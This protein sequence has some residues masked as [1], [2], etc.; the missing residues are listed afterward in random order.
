MY[1]VLLADDER[2]VLDS[3]KTLIPWDALGLELAC[4]AENGLEALQGALD[5]SPEIIISDI[6]MPLLSGLD[7][8]ERLRALDLDCEIIILSGYGEFSYAQRAIRCGVRQYLIKPTKKEELL[9][10]L[11]QT[12]DTLNL[13]KDADEKM[14]VA[15]LDQFRFPIAKG[16]LL[17][18]LSD[19]GGFDEAWPSYARELGLDNRAGA[20]LL[21]IDSGSTNPLFIIR[22]EK[23]LSLKTVLPLLAVDGHYLVLLEV[24]DVNALDSFAALFAGQV[25]KSEGSLMAIVK[26]S[27]SKA[28]LSKDIRLYDST[29]HESVLKK[30]SPPLNQLK[31]LLDIKQDLDKDSL[32]EIIASV[33]SSCGL[34]ESKAMLMALYSSIHDNEADLSF[35]RLLCDISSSQEACGYAE[36]LIESACDGGS[37]SYPVRM[38]KRHVRENIADENLSLKYIAE[39]MLFMN[40]GYLSRLFV[41]ETGVKFSEYINSER[42]NKAKTLLSVYKD[43]PVARVAELVGFGDN[44]RYFS[45][46]FKK[47][48][49][50]TPSE[51]AKTH[52]KGEL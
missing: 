20:V 23:N 35:L 48:A 38:I 40:V 33:F 47:Y 14:R 3:L 13:K 37:E 7:L 32:H 2:L 12:V 46:V 45:Q 52:G 25:K 42:M 34:F 17:G 31:A 24:T 5:Y 39:N 49:H 4:C 44:P 6:K 21:E 43:M 18:L 51:W 50:A 11:R 28:C 41:K 9:E 10:V 1:K 15:L 36:R 26:T 29:G 27:V 19:S 22:Q 16:A 30:D 8:I